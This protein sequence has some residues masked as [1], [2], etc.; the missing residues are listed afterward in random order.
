[1]L[2]LKLAT[3]VDFTEARKTGLKMYP[4]KDFVRTVDGP[5]QPIVI[6]KVSPG[7]ARLVAWDNKMTDQSRC[8]RY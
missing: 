2:S 5:S 1:V 7:P 8:S 3:F 6:R 4:G